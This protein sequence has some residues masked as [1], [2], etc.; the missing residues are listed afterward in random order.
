MPALATRH[1]LSDSLKAARSAAGL[2]Q[3]EVASALGVHEMTVSGWER[4]ASAPKDALLTRLAN[5]YETTAATLRYGEE[6]GLPEDRVPKIAAGLSKPIR[7]WMHEF[8]LGLAKADVSD[9]EIEEAKRVLTAPENYQFFVGGNADEPD[10]DK[11]MEGLEL[12]AA[13]I[14]QTL[15]ARGYKLGK[16]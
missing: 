5:L 11:I 10:D 9:R 7:I 15:R 6:R 8:L 4:G 12:V 14:S 16:K 3:A 1:S 2:T 13:V